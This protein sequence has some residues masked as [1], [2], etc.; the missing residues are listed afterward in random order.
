MLNH[1]DSDYRRKNSQ[2]IKFQII[3]IDYIFNVKLNIEV[4]GY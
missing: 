1:P 2:I 3:N 4:K